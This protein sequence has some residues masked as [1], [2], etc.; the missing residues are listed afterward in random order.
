MHS[1]THRQLIATWLL[2]L[3]LPLLVHGQASPSIQFFMPDGTLP[4]REMRFT[5]AMDNGRIETFFT[6]SKG[7]FLITRS[8]NLKPDAEY[9]V[10]VLSDGLAYDTTS[11]TFKEFGVYYIPIYL[12]PFRAAATKPA[13]LIDLAEFDVLA[14]ED[15]R[16]AYSVAMRAYKDGQRDQAVRD[17][18]RAIE[19]YPN[20]FRAL[21]DL[22]VILMKQG[23]LDDAAKMFERAIKTAPRVYYPRLNFAIINTRRGRHKEALSM[24]E[25]LHKEAPDLSE[26]RIALGDSL[27]ANNKL[28]EAEHHLR[29]A[30]SDPKLSRTATAD[31]HY[32]LG[33]LLNRKQQFE[34][35]INE[36][37]QAVEV[38]SNSARIHLQLG[39]A[40]LQVGKVDEAERELTTAYKIGGSQMGGAQLMLGHIYFQARK[41]ESARYAFERYL[42]DVPHAPNADEV[43]GVIE[44]INVALSR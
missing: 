17:L 44:K 4:P 33:L 8:L 1:K 34:Q 29:A 41:Y 19:I 27:A 13:G 31:V 22:G 37:R 28:N 12:K 32:K 14:P 42:S 10:T 20:Y 36:L 11:V 16:Q 21:N 40:L 5:M 7:K 2:A 9:R 15:A 30:V 3:S 25:Q 39:G 23:R 18:E 35:A 38:L 24:L 26:V 43:R 6:D